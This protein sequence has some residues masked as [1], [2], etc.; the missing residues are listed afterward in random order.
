M[1][2]RFSLCEIFAISEINK[3]LLNGIFTE[4]DTSIPTK[5]IINRLNL[6]E[7]QID[8]ISTKFSGESTKKYTLIG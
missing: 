7:L 4:F 2:R 3:E 1:H 8:D 5:N 6:G